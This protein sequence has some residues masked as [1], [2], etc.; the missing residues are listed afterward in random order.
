VSARRPRPV[1]EWA[2][3]GAAA[4]LAAML[5]ASRL[6]PGPEF[7]LPRRPGYALYRAAWALFAAP[8]GRA[9][10]S[11]GV[12]ALLAACAAGWARSERAHV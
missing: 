3:L 5:F 12:A 10:F 8:A 11:T 2:S 4:G 6:P 1:A 9:A 7:L